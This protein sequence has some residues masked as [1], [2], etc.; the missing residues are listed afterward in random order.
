MGD[1]RSAPIIERPTVAAMAS[2]IGT[3]AASD[4]KGCTHI[5]ILG[6]PKPSFRVSKERRMPSPPDLE[7]TDDLAR[8]QLPP[9]IRALL[10]EFRR[11]YP[12][13]RTGLAPSVEPQNP[14][15]HPLMDALLVEYRKQGRL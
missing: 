6:P 4:R 14:S 2:S 9:G 3:V 13:F 11:R 7:P 1:L 15:P 12:A 8:A 5:H 10:E